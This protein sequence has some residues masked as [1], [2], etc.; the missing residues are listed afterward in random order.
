MSQKEFWNSKFSKEGFLYGT[1]PNA[2]IKSCEG[3][4]KKSQR[5]LCLGEG[6]G[7]NAIY[8]AK[9]GFDVVALDASD[10]GLL[11]LETQAIENNLKIKTRCVDLNEWEPSKK[12]GTIV[13]SYLHMYE[14]DREKLFLKIESCL[15]D[16]GFFVGEFFS[17]NQINYTSGGPKDL[18]LLYSVDDFLN[19]FNSC[20]KHKIEEIETNLD[21]GKGHQGKASVIRVIIQKK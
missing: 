13:A 19:S 1:K 16:N 9:K 3:N 18:S 12:Y 20:I 10:I 2:F 7:R 8:F 6:E 11:K 21:E 15:K 5:F 4:F 14:D 17:K